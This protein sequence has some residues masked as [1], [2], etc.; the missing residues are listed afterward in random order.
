MLGC[1]QRWQLLSAPGRYHFMHS[2]VHKDNCS[3]F[4]SFLTTKD[5]EKKKTQTK[6]KVRDGRRSAAPTTSG[7]AAG[8]QALGLLCYGTKTQPLI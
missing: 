4:N 8:G 5:Q 1:L 7:S 6:Q 2:A 3:A